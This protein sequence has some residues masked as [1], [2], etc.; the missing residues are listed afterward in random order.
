MT[1]SEKT[2]EKDGETSNKSGEA[3][4]KPEKIETDA[5]LLLETPTDDDKVIKIENDL[6]ELNL[7][8]IKSSQTNQLNQKN[9]QVI[10]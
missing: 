10:Q 4:E 2:K 8:H 6:D 3:N 9:L 1:I 7:E 5:K